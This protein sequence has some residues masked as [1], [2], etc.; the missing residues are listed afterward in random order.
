[1]STAD[2]TLFASIIQRIERGIYV[3]QEGRAIFLNRRF[4]QIFGFDNVND[5]IGR[6]LFDEIYPDCDSRDFYRSVHADML[7]SG[8][9]RAAW[10]QL[11]CRADGTPFWLEIEAHVIDVGGR[12]AICGIC[13]DQTDC[14]LMARAMIHSQ[15]TLRLLLDA[16]EDRVYVV[17]EDYR[18]VYANRKMREAIGDR[19]ELPCYTACRGHDQPCPDCTRDLVF[20]SDVPVYKEYRNERNSRWY[21]VIELAV[22]MPGSGQRTKL[23]VARDISER[24]QDEARI[25]SLSGKL[26]SAQE[27]E[28]RR[29]SRDLHD[30]LGQRLNAVKVG[31]DLLDGGSDGELDR[32]LRELSGDLQEA[33]Q[34]VRDLAGDLRPPALEKVGLVEAIR[35]HCERTAQRHGLHIDFR[36][37]GLKGLQIETRAQIKLFRIVQEGL[38]NVLRHAKASNVWVRLVA[39]HPVLRLRISDD[40]QGFSVPE[41]KQ[42]V[43]HGRH[44][45]LAGMAERAELLDGRFSIDSEPGKGTRLM[46][47]IPLGADET[48]PPSY[49][50]LV[51]GS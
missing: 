6:P 15:E 50:V 11:S 24:K 45:G 9:E 33:I 2:Q 30:D 47:E 40:G 37:A 19:G 36:A 8:Q 14:Q 23:A 7:A 31:L 25:R 18:I 39:S 34:A 5:L 22:N 3:V 28:R 51:A 49:P 4:G 42:R 17:D 13:L 27:D 48:L 46:V 16:M 38:N 10:A 32:R 20:A 35:Q 44:L 43:E 12:P 21:S 41:W 1:M 29:L 26:L